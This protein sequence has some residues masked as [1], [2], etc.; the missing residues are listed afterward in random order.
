MIVVNITHYVRLIIY[1][2]YGTSLVRDAVLGER[3]DLVMV[4][5]EQQYWPYLWWPTWGPLAIW[6]HIILT[7]DNVDK[8]SGQSHGALL[9]AVV[10]CTVA[11][12]Q[13]V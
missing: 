4:D 11:V 1:Y 7:L 6:V 12:R 9:F 2:I 13:H 3:D 8:G 10:H 5:V